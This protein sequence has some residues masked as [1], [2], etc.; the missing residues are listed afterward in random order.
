MGAKLEPRLDLRR[1]VEGDGNRGERAPSKRGHDRDDGVDDAAAG[2]APRFVRG[3]GLP[4]PGRHGVGVA[5]ARHGAAAAGGDQDPLERDRRRPPLR[6]AVRPRGA[7]GGPPQP[8]ERRAG[9]RRRQGGRHRLHG[10]R[11]GR[12]RLPGR[13]RRAA[14]AVP[15]PARV[16]DRARRGARPGRGPRH[17][18]HPP[19]PQAGQHP[20]DPR[21][22]RE[23]RRLRPRAQPAEQPADHAERDV[24][25]HAAVRLA[26]AVPGRG[27]RHGVR[28]LLARRRPLRA[29]RGQAAARGAHAAGAVPE[30]PRGAGPPAGRAAPGGPGLALGRRG[31]AAG[32]GPEGPRRRGRRHGRG[33]RPDPGPAARGPAGARGGPARARRVV[34]HAHEQDLPRRVGR[35]GLA[36]RPLG[37]GGADRPP[38]LVRLAGRH[39]AHGD[40]GPGR[41]A[42]APSRPPS[43][44]RCSSRWPW[45]P[46]SPGR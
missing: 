45:R 15:D 18:G 20:A 2:E 4:R 29:A 38:R 23:A 17:E 11:A 9:L 1:Q 12:G 35:L 32:E 5:R 16:R 3:G 25:R 10:P 28:P 41:A 46:S 34:G 33:P 42:A 40:H 27:G 24:P 14:A 31:P 43:A 21:G 26:R 36:L 44:R 8:P 19:R 37:V 7:H 13:A 6:G 30:D 39:A 22:G